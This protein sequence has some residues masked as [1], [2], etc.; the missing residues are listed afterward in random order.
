[1]EIIFISNLDSVE[2][3]YTVKPDGSGLKPIRTGDLRAFFTR[4]SP[5][6]SKLAIITG[7]WPASTITIMN[8]DGS[9]PIPVQIAASSSSDPLALVQE[10][11]KLRDANEKEKALAF[12]A[13]TA[14]IW[15]EE[16]TGPGRPYKLDSP[17]V[18]WDEFFNS[19]R[20]YRNWKAEG[21]TVSVE[22]DETNDYYRL[23]EWEPAPVLLT[24]WLDDENKIAGYMVKGLGEGPPKNRMKEFKEWATKNDPE[25]LA[26]LMPEGKINPDGDRPE[27]WKKILV[28]WRK[29]VGLKP[30]LLSD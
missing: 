15:F 23:L 10:F 18:H 17:W 25:E 7:G 12:L 29:A 30:V 27:R 21:N 16:K 8:A 1:K 2:A 19:K 3:I 14:R 22:I 11:M 13:D 4:Y 24:W 28:E 6:G 5:D 26:Y 9:N 20:I